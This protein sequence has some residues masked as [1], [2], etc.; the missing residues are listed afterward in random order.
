MEKDF[1]PVLLGID[2]EQIEKE[3][4]FFN[5]AITDMNRI[6]RLWLQYFGHAMELQHARALLTVT[7]VDKYLKEHYVLTRENPLAE[8]AR[9]GEYKLDVLVAGAVIPPVDELRDAVEGLT[10]RLKI[11]KFAEKFLANIDAMKTDD[12]FYFP[13]SIKESI[14]NKYTFYTENEAQNK[15]LELVTGVCESLNKINDI[16]G[17]ITHRDLTPILQ[18]CI[19]TVKGEKTYGELGSSM[20]NSSWTI[21]KLIPYYAMFKVGNNSLLHFVTKNI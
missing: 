13:E 5:M 19:T 3:T 7:Y 16:S 17:G 8:L 21:P 9:K 6:N 4:E 15:V 10:S 1:K 12:G 14:K 11:Q 18:Q 20:G 2:P